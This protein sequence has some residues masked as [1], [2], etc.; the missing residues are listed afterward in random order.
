MLTTLWMNLLTTEKIEG[1][2]TWLNGL[3]VPPWEKMPVTETC[4]VANALKTSYMG[5]L[6]GLCRFVY[7]A[8]DGICLPH[9]RGGVS[10]GR[11]GE[12]KPGGA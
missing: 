9:A 10:P 8:G 6:I 4:V 1:T 3:G 5:C 12:T 7:L 2:R 11:G